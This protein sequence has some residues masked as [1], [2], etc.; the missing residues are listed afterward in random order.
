MRA[1]FAPR[2]ED[3]PYLRRLAWTIVIGAVLLVVWRTAHLLL[4]VFGSV[5]GAVIFLALARLLRRAGLRHQRM[6]LAAAIAIALLLFSLAVW[7]LSAE[8]GRQIASL[9]A[10]LP[11][12]IADVERTLGQSPVGEALVAAAQAAAG[13]STFAELLGTLSLGAGEVALNFVIV[14]VGAIFIAADPGV[15]RRGVVLLVAPAL[16]PRAD[17]ALAE[18]SHA[19]RR[20][21]QAQLISMASMGLLVTAALRIVG[22]ESWAALGLLAG[23][24]EFIP[25]VGPTLAMLPALALAF[26]E[27]G[28][29]VVEVLLA[30][31]AVRLVQTNFITPLVNRRVIAIPPALTLFVILGAGAVFGFYGMFFAGALLVVAFVGV[32]EL[33]LRDTL[34]E[35]GIDAL[36]HRK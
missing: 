19:L 9:V 32:R 1:P 21:L 14:L 12:A 31:V 3:L 33:Y 13:G 28:G 4:L 35:F 5:L 34:G 27:G 17:R 7:L 16:R 18:I 8:F 11:Q 29:K 6:S 23:V 26:A 15:Y 10:G 36:P 2:P 24:S 22:L 20:W 30:Y 25:Y